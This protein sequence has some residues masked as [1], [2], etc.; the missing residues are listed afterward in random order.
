MIRFTKISK[1][2]VFQRV[3]IGC[4]RLARARPKILSNEM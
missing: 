4:M 1:Y 2:Q 3:F